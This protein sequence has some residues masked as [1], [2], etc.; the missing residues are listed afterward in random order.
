[1]PLVGGGGGS[2]TGEP[3]RLREITS[4]RETTRAR[5][6]GGK[7]PVARTVHATNLVEQ[8]AMTG[9]EPPGPLSASGRTG[10]TSN[11]VVG[12]SVLRCAVFWL[13]LRKGG[14]PNM[15]YPS[16]GGDYGTRSRP[17]RPTPSRSGPVG[18]AVPVGTVTL[19]QLE[20][21]LPYSL[22]HTRQPT[23]LWSQ[24]LLSECDKTGRVGSAAKSR[25]SS[26]NASRLVANWLELA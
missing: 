24:E 25:R 9:A 22:K 10:R 13:G 23:C 14:Q 5:R 18:G 3:P 7:A 17:W 12:P 6:Q 1:V 15:P 11:Y 26:A 2:R 8:Q 4:E 20:R 21:Y 16:H 19:A